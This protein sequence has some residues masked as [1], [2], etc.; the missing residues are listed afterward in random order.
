MA[1]IRAN[2]EPRGGVGHPIPS[3]AVVQDW[4]LGLQFNSS[5]GLLAEVRSQMFGKVFMEALS[6]SY[7]QCLPTENSWIQIQEHLRDPHNF[8][9]RSFGD[10]A[11]PSSGTR[12]NGDL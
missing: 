5:V 10:P 1:V 7:L 11:L 4:S 2:Q 3:S 12:R 8:Q 6:L 9:G